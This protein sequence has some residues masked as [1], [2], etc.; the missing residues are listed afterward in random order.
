[1]GGKGTIKA[2]DKFDA[3]E[4]EDGRKARG[5]PL[6]AVSVTEK[7]IYAIDSSHC[8]CKRY[9]SAKF[10]TFA[11]ISPMELAE[12]KKMTWLK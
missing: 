2:G 1:M 8:H 7:G 3:F 12:R 6:T 4:A 11:K 9:F 5:C 10:F